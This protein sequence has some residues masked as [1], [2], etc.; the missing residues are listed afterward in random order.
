MWHI[1]TTDRF[2]EW[3]TS[4]DVVDRE[5]VLVSLLLLQDRGPKLSRPH[6]DTIKGSNYPNMKE[7]RVQ[8]KGNPIRAFFAFDPVRKGI[9]LCA[10]TKVGKDKRF[11]NE[12][13]PIA[14]NEY[15]EHL[16]KYKVK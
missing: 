10:G 5:N 12:M 6:A 7:L 11:Y 13:I 8:S 1:E 2:D 14:D 4:L 3:F 15:L 9:V 16:E